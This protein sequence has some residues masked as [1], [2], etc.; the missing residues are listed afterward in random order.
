MHC[1]APDGAVLPL[2]L[3][4]PRTFVLNFMASGSLYS[5][6]FHLPSLDFTWS[7]NMCIFDGCDLGHSP[8]FALWEG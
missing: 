7:L 1:S 6:I 8:K 2:H 3:I 4:S 5:L